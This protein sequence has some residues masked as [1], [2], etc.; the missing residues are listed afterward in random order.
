MT[1][2]RVSF[3]VT[4]TI[5]LLLVVYEPDLKAQDPKQKGITYEGLDPGTYSGPDSERSLTNLKTTG[6]EWVSL[7]VTQYQETISS[8]TIAPTSRTMP[9]DDLIEVIDQAHQ[10]GLKVMLKPHVDVKDN[11][12]R[13]Y[14]GEAFTTEAEWTAWFTTYQ[15]F[16]YHYANL[17][18]VNGVEQFDIGTEMRGTSHRETDWRA[19]I[20]GVRTRYPPPGS[21]VY[22]ASY[23]NAG[24]ITWWDAVDYIGIDAYYELVQPG[25]NDPTVEELKAGWAQPV[26]DLANLSANNGNKKIL[27][28]EIGYLSNQGVASRP[29]DYLCG[30]LDL[31]EQQDA[32]QATLESVFNEPWFGGMYW[33]AW[34]ADPL[35][36]GPDSDGYTP[37]GKPAE[38]VLRAWY[39][40][41]GSSLYGPLL[42]P[43]PDDNQALAL[44]GDSLAVGWW[45]DSPYQG[46]ITDFAATD[47][48]YSGSHAISVSQDD[49][50]ALALFTNTPFDSTPYYWLEFYLRGSAVGDQHLWITFVDENNSILR[51]RPIDDRLYINGGTISSDRWKRVRIPLSD[52]NAAEK[53]LSGFMIQDRCGQESTSFWIDEIR[54]L[55]EGD[56][57]QIYLPVIIKS[58]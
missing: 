5:L 7:V 33:Y 52:M 46:A 11:S 24:N 38:A 40:N 57:L 56:L 44:Y 49:W 36:G 3:M 35:D 19:L 18:K 17:A 21:I 34:S 12:W 32:Y 26:T 37:F 43:P 58:S 10:L 2:V 48:V 25:N 14:I 13:A 16:I 47:Q 54:L 9:D 53:S 4:I 51:K 29:W 45:D 28:P 41:P 20:N 6:A 23:D 15:N 55:S 42:H 50:G 22:A 27:F 31:Q 1:K 30:S 8:T 39:G